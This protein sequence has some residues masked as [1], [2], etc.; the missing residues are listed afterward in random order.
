[1]RGMAGLALVIFLGGALPAGAQMRPIPIRMAAPPARPVLMPNRSITFVRPARPPVRVVDGSAGAVRPVTRP[2]VIAT[3]PAAPALVTTTNIPLTP[4]VTSLGGAPIPLDQLLNPAPGLGFDF[5]HLAAINRNL[6]TQ[7]II[8]PLTR[9]QLALIQQLPQVLPAAIW[10]FGGWG[11]YAEAPVVVQP[12]QPQVIVV[13]PAQPAATAPAPPSPEAAAPPQPPLPDVGQFLLVERDGEVIHAA[14][15]SVQ[16]SQ[17][18]YITPGGARRA[19]PLDQIDVRLTEERN[20]ERGTI[21][22]LA[23]GTARPQS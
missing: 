19:I 17:V 20:A 3:A 18:V 11:T 8:D 22:H 10:G 14:A 2:P 21:L 15:F 4:V 23:G 16:G 5:T 1:M 7:A 6:A 12:A 9:H 13:P